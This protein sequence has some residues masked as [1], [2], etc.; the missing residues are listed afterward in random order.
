M[1]EKIKLKVLKSSDV[2]LMHSLI[3]CF[4]E[5]FD[6]KETYLGN[7]PDD[8]YLTELLDERT[9]IAL[10]ALDD[11]EVVG[12]LVAYEFKKFEQHRSEICIYDLAVYEAYQRQGVASSL[13]EYIKQIAKERGAWFVYIHAD[14]DNEAAINLYSKLGVRVE[15]IPFDLS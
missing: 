10:V 3:N 5:V 7:K 4:A 2:E 9:F 11:D 15:A 6:E 14:S 8:A 12:G 1:K 13:I